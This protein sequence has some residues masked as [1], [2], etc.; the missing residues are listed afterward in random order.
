LA[1]GEDWKRGFDSSKR[2]KRGNISKT[3]IIY[4]SSPNGLGIGKGGNEKK[5][6]LRGP[7]KEGVK[8]GSGGKKLETR[9]SGVET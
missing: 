6:K 8:P 7:S 5:N 9:K 3:K 1:G 2:E 4:Y